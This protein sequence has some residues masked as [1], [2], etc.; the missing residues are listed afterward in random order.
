MYCLVKMVI[1]HCYVSLP[2]G[3]IFIFIDSPKN[4]T[5]HPPEGSRKMIFLLDFGV[6]LSFGE[7]TTFG[8]NQS[9]V[10]ILL[11]LQLDPTCQYQI[12]SNFESTTVSEK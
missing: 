5:Q 3:R 2:E 6:R 1:F 10:A 7:G 9:L 12:T 4:P 8:Q 11:L